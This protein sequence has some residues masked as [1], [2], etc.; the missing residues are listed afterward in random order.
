MKNIQETLNN[1]PENSGVYIM[2]NADDEILYIGKAINLK[3]RVKQYFDG[4]DERYQIT[5]LV[6]KVESVEFIV[7]RNETEAL[8]LEANLVRNHKPPYNILLKDDTHYP[9]VKITK[10]SEEFPRVLIVRKVDNDKN[11]YFGPFTDTA[12]LR[13]VV[14][15]LCKILKIRSCSHNVSSKKT[16][17]P[18]IDFSM[19]LCSAPCAQN[20]SAQDYGALIEQAVKFFQGQRREIVSF[21]E[22]QMAQHSLNL[23]FE[24]A[25]QTRDILFGIRKLVHK[26]NIDFRNPNL[27]CDV[28]A[29]CEQS[30]NLCF[31]IMNVRNGNLIN[32]N[33]IIIPL[34][35][36]GYDSRAKLIV[37][38]YTT[39]ANAVPRNIVL[40]QE[41]AEEEDLIRDFI[42]Q[43][44]KS[45]TFI[46]KST[47]YS[48]KLVSLAQKNCEIYLAQ[49]YRNNPHEVL[50]EL[51][52]ICKLPRPPRTI[53]AFDISNVGDKFCVAGM[54]RFEDGDPDKA[55]YRRFKIR[56]IATQNDFAMLTEAITRRLSRLSNENK[57]F[58]DLL[59]IDGGKGQLSA[60]QKAIVQFENAPMLLS[61]AEKNETIIS[62]YCDC[63][64]VQ[65]NENHP[66]RRLMQRIRD[67]VHRFAIS[68][69]RQMRGRQFN[70]T[71]LQDIEGIGEKKAE[72]LLKAFGSAQEIA[73]K[74]VEELA[75]VKGIS[76][77]DA[78]RILEELS[79]FS[80]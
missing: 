35:A 52:A 65:L 10:A 69:H 15:S 18:C 45:R 71:I 39:S 44:Y 16:I 77:K 17:R 11:P 60:A 34:A 5:P 79:D 8:I 7:C 73:E 40:S 46:A 37:D 66:V 50:Q 25:A 21:L 38:Y 33:N 53:E 70:R 31:T 72:S 74:S 56:S 59:L 24:K 58:P 47:G 1:I 41:F 13:L 55:N 22:N 64:E 57:P 6:A 28:F 26:Q 36:W 29:V 54:V 4:S 49:S 61:L 76:A 43:K 9:Y 62:P 27:N 12:K 30:K 23:E 32:Q 42:A 20:I 2:K 51:T 80:V 75:A 63:R 3:S 19:N 67:E 78:E 14:Q 48:A 68:Y